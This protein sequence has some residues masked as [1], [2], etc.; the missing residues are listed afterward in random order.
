MPRP[1]WRPRLPRVY[2]VAL[3]VGACV[4]SGTRADV[5]WMVAP[6]TS[7]EALAITPGGGRIGG[8]LAGTFDS[9]LADVADRHLSTGR[10]VVH[11]VTPLES[12]MCGVEAG[13]VAMFMVVPADQFPS[14]FWQ[15]LLDRQSVAVICHTRDDEVISVDTKAQSDAD[16]ELQAIIAQGPPQSVITDGRITTVFSPVTRLVIAGRGPIADALAAQAVLLGWKAIIEP[17]P[18][19]VAGLSSQLSPL[20]AVVVMGHDVESS[21]QCLMAALESSAGYIGA[22]GSLS[23]QQARADWL[24]YRDIT[25][26]SRVDGPAGVAIG[27]TS[28]AEIA[29]SITAAAIYCLKDTDA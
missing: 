12:Q 27:A 28:P 18:D 20:D 1:P 9:L 17:R 22:L 10:V 29:V 2:D 16:D 24:A 6:R 15:K 26:I 5:A 23:M 7:D 3:S 8:I 13:T 19:R 11:T 21:S 4:R 25:D 14:S